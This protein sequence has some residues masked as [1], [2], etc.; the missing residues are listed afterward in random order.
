LKE[1]NVT[2]FANNLNNFT[3]RR[4]LYCVWVPVCQGDQTRLE[5]RWIDPNADPGELRQARMLSSVEK[6][7][8]QLLP[9]RSLQC[10]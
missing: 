6:E 2:N 8:E 9:G 3:G 4:G 1:G 10:A 7:E 5:M